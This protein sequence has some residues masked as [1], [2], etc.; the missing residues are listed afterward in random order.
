MSQI[1]VVSYCN[2]TLGDVE[3]SLFVIGTYMEQNKAI[4]GLVS[5]LYETRNIFGEGEKFSS[6]RRILGQR[7][8]DKTFHMTEMELHQLVRE[9]G[10]H[11]NDEWTFRITKHTVQ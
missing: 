9:Y 10:V 7:L 3:D 6:Q 5:F 11:F 8:L 2:I 4:R 1:Y